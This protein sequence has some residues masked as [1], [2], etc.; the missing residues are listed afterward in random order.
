MAKRGNG[1]G[2]IYYSEKLGKWVGQFTA[3]RKADGKIN[4][5]SIYGNTRKEVKEKIT[6]ALSQ[7]QDNIFIDKTDITIYSLGKHIIDT[8]LET[9]TIKE[10]TYNTYNYPLQKIQESN[11]GNMKVQKVTL[12]HIQDFLNSCKDLS[13]AYIEKIYILLNLI[14]EY[15]INNDYI[16]K[17][18]LRTAIRPQSTRPDKVVEALTIDEQKELIKNIQ[19]RLYKNIYYIALYTGMRIGE[20]LAL[21]T[22]DIDF[23]NKIIHVTR[24][25]TKNKKK[26]LIIGKQTKTHLNR[27]VPITVLFENNLQDSMENVIPNDNNLIF[28]QKNGSILSPANLNSDFK[29]VCQKHNI[30]KG[31]DVN[32]HMLRHTYATRCIESGMQASVLQ[33]LLG[34][35]N[36]QT[37]L[38]TYTTVFDKFRN[39]ELDKSV[40]YMLE[41]IG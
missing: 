14:F 34:H 26:Q 8:K 25:L 6:K 11:I 29:R 33:K 15:A 2:T 40:S 22:T 12:P 35:K 13:N 7:V 18:P 30:N 23:E 31:W 3:G 21:Q 5:K 9:N 20:I 28:T 10:T 1:E 16:I 36:I 4:R 19:N 27:D 24:T 37:T 39:N 38:N 17:N 32:F 41:K